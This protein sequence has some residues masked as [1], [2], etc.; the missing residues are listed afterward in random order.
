MTRKIVLATSNRAYAAGLAAYLRETEPGWETSAFTHETAL[1]VRLQDGG[2]DALIGDPALLQQANGWLGGVSRVSALV[3]E[4]GQTGGVWPEIMIYQPLPQVAAGIRG[5]LADTLPA[6]AEGCQ[7]LTVYSAV[8]GVGKTMTALNL[9]KLAGERGLRTLYL[10]LE[11]LN[12]TSILFGTK[13]ADSL[14]RLLYLVQTKPE[15]FA[16][17]AAQAIRYHPYLHAD[18]ID[19][20][21]YPNERL[22]MTPELLSDFIGCLRACGRYDLIVADPDSG[23]GSWHMGLIR[24]SDRVAWLVTSDWQCMEKTRKLMQFWQEEEKGWGN[25]VYFLRNKGGLNAS[26]AWPLPSQ[27]AAELPFVPQWQE[28][29]DPGRVFGSAAFCGSLEKLLNDWKI[30]GGCDDGIHRS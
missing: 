24:M 7:L 11:P 20:P 17:D 9:A 29:A 18:F 26:G 22:A 14:S 27:P 23:L 25:H 13:E 2:V 5:L 10:N 28:S 8:G 6:D 15:D 16:A 21:D 30:G 19:A 4:P 1:R 3:E 12:T